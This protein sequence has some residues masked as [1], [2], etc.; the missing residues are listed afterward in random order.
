MWNSKTVVLSVIGGKF[1]QFIKLLI[2][3]HYNYKS[4]LF[5]DKMM[6]SVLRTLVAVNNPVQC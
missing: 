1:S 3:G 2:A 4:N 6:S 5:K